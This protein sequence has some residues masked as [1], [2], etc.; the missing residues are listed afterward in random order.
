MEPAVSLYNG[1]CKIYQGH[2][3][4]V[5]KQLPAESVQ[6]CITSPP[7][8]GLRSYGTHPQVWD[9]AEGC[10]H[11]WVAFTRK[12]TTGGK[13]SQ[14]VHV[15]GQENFQIVP[16]SQQATC[17]KCG[18]WRGELG[19]EPSPSMY[20]SHLVQIFREVR[21][22]LHPTGT[23][24]VNIGDSYA[25]NR[26]YQVGS[27]KGG[28]KHSPAQADQT[29]NRVPD[30]MKPKD[31]IGIPWMLA[32][33]LRDDGWWLRADNIWEKPNVMPESVEDRPN[34]SHEYFFLLSKQPQYYYDH[35]AV[36]EPR[37][38]SNNGRRKAI[39]K[40]NGTESGFQ[41]RGS[42]LAESPY[43]AHKGSRRGLPGVGTTLVSSDPLLRNRRTVWS[44]NT[45]PYKDAHFAVFP[46][47]LA[48]IPILAGSPS[49]G[50]VLDPFA[51]SGTTLFTALKH[52]RN[53]V[54]IELN[55]EYCGLAVDRIT[56]EIGELAEGFREVL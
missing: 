29:G 54:G 43:N 20:I 26:S 7:Y 24:W 12:G 49:N 19:A 35:K 30:G 27:T 36:R 55:A 16:D 45:R 32:F 17:E 18:A 44:I 31:L 23:L 9:A 42:A 6:T 2:A 51:G 50:V 25:A 41:A 4:D 40:H 15:K 39:Q 22:V 3:L 10:E 46:P 37:N 28:K 34:K 52:G 13:K 38:D 5:L 14:K 8:Y 11:S 53:A 47:A 21:R 1:R 33:A 56:K 48:E